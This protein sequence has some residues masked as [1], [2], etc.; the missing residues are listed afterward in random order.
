MNNFEKNYVNFQDSNVSCVSNAVNHDFIDGL[1]KHWRQII[2][3]VDFSLIK[4]NE[5]QLITEFSILLNQKHPIN[6]AFSTRF[7]SY[8]VELESL[9]SNFRIQKLE[10]SDNCHICKKFYKG[11]KIHF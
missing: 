3:N 2:T 1:C 6:L 8:F 7:A 9:L 5:S 11:L 4:F 10:K